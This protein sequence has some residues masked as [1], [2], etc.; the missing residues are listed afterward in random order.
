MEEILLAGDAYWSYDYEVAE[1]DAL[2]NVGVHFSGVGPYHNHRGEI[3]LT[4][5]GLY[6]NGDVNLAFKLSDLEQLY[7]GF[8]E[9]FPRSL[10]KNFGLMAQPLRLQASTAEGDIYIFINHNMFGTQN[11]LWFDTIRELLSD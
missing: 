6:I 3:A 1:R 8:D 2:D 4:A 7:I 5:E 9:V 10:V 11:Q